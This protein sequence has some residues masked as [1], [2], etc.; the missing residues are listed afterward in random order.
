MSRQGSNASVKRGPVWLRR[1][2]ASAL[3]AASCR[4]APAPRVIPI[5][6]SDVVFVQINAAT[7]SKR[8]SVT[9]KLH[10]T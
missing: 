7:P 2:S 10:N 4:E 8:V 6:Q 9:V 5:A 3:L 1:R